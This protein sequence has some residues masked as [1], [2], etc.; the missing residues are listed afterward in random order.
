[1]CHAKIPGP[2][3]HRGCQEAG[4]DDD[5]LFHVHREVRFAPHLGKHA[6]QIEI[7]LMVV[8]LRLAAAYKPD[9]EEVIMIT[10]LDN[11]TMIEPPIHVRPNIPISIISFTVL[12]NKMSNDTLGEQKE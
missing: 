6:G 11:Q 10:N 12:G 3:Q 5:G 9:K 8:W 4:D 1:M 7:S 2:D